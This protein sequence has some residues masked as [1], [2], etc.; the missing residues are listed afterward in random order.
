[1]GR[2]KLVAGEACRHGHPWNRSPDGKRCLECYS[3]TRE[4]QKQR[5]REIGMPERKP[6]ARRHQPLQEYLAEEIPKREERRC[7]LLQAAIEKQRVINARV[8]ARE[9]R[10]ELRRAT[11]AARLQEISAQRE[12]KTRRIL[13]LAEFRR[14]RVEKY[15]K[16]NAEAKARRTERERI[17]QERLAF[18]ETRPRAKIKREGG[19]GRPR[20]PETFKTK[21]CRQARQRGNKAGLVSTVTVDDLRWPEFCPVLGVRLEYRTWDS[22]TRSR[23]SVGGVSHSM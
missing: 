3:L 9:A 12:A 18:W 14:V 13:E 23:A 22:G 7:A 8:A 19:R 15:E 16:A 20:N 17:K 1:M 6:A 10:R 21:L 5:L 2:R 4:R 11:T